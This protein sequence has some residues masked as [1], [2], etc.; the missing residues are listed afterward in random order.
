MTQ[1]LRRKRHKDRRRR[2]GES[3]LNLDLVLAQRQAGYHAILLLVVQRN[4][5]TVV[6]QSNALRLL[7]VQ[8]QLMVVVRRVHHQQCRQEEALVAV[9]QFFQQLF[10]FAAVSS[11][12]RR[13]NFHV[14]S[15]ADGFFLLINLHLIQRRELMLNVLD[16]C[17]L[18]NRL[19]VKAHHKRGIHREE[20]RQTAV[21][22][23]RCKDGEEADRAHFAA[24][25]ETLPLPEFEGRGN[26]K[27]LRAQSGGG[28]PFPVEQERCL[29]IQMKHIVHQL[30]ALSAI[31]RSG[32]RPKALE[33]IEQICLHALQTR[34]CRPVVF[35]FH[36]ES[37]VLSFAQPV[38]ALGKLVLQ[39]FRVFAADCVEAVRLVGK[40]NALLNGIRIRCQV[41][42][43]EL[44]MHAAVKGV[45]EVAPA[46]EDG[47]F[48]FV[49]RQLIVDVPELHSL[50]VVTWADAADAIRPHAFIRN[51]LLYGMR[52][53]LPL[54]TAAHEC[55]QL[56]FLS[57]CQLDFFFV[58]HEESSAP[59][60]DCG[61]SAQ[62]FDRNCR[63]ARR[64]C[65]D[66]R[67]APE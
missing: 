38:A 46:L 63:S 57:P 28:K 33:V 9:L 10:C 52:R 7:H 29:R 12:I 49:L 56:P 39:H 23:F 42:K 64:G 50:S 51:R 45:Q 1:F 26:D 53:F 40:Q 67:I 55:L 58:C 21:I 20:L 44:Q 37:Q 11:Q 65:A 4:Q 18:V 16:G 14:I 19:Q 13:Q 30:Q 2:S 34:L 61:Y 41:Q 32:C 8:I 36:A 6:L 31:H 35:R 43:R 60:A 3:A 27:V 54:L 15:G 5:L 59:P 62:S 17:G 66:A 24:H 47:A 48:I 22:E 25:A